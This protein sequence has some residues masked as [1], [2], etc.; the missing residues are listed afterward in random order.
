MFS[1]GHLFLSNRKQRAQ[2]AMSKRGQ[3]GT[4]G[5]SSANG[6]AQVNEFGD[7]EAETYYIGAVQHVE[8]EE[9]FSARYE[10]FRKPAEC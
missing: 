7:G 6:E 1:C 2:S 9:T 3:E 10:R 4:S 8:Y 5:E